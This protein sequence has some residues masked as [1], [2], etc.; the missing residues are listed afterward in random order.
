MPDDNYVSKSWLKE[1]DRK[2]SRIAYEGPKISWPI[3]KLVNESPIKIVEKPRD[4]RRSL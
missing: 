2:E 4:I 3:N 1:L